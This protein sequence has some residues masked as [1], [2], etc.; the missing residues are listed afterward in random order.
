MV[1]VLQMPEVRQRL[2]ELAIIL[3][4]LVFETPLFIEIC[5]IG[6]FARFGRDRWE[7]KRT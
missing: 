5:R 1:K 6:V 4:I 7:E 3:T 2:V